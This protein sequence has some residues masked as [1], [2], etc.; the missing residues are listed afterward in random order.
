MVLNHHII[1]GSLETIIWMNRR[2]IICRKNISDKVALCE[3]GEVP[4][5]HNTMVLNKCI[6]EN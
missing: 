4:F 5:L 1:D 3:H 2:L 6:K